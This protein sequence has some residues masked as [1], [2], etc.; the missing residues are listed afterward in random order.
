MALVNGRETYGFPKKIAERIALERSGAKV[1]GSVVRRGTEL[2]R[3][4]ASLAGA[5][6]AADLALLADAALDGAGRPCRRMSVFNYRCFP[7]PDLRGFDAPPRLVRAPVLLRARP[8]LQRAAAR[9][10]VRSS[11]ADPLGEVPLLGEPLACTY[12]LWD[13]TLVHGRTVAREWWPW[14]ALRYTAFKNDAGAFLLGT[15]A[16]RAARPPAPDGRAAR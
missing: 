13:M 3:I 11:E 2:L 4:E 8:G 16:G 15:A 5:V 10:I 6:A 1:V 7:R 9:V 12:G 14:R